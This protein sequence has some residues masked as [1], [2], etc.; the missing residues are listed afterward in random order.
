MCN[1]EVPYTLIN[2]SNYLVDA[3][4][5]CDE[6]AAQLKFWI[7]NLKAVLGPGA[8]AQ[9]DSWVVPDVGCFEY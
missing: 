3:L 6:D 7:K 8:S 9:L 2:E 4:I 1:R 5:D